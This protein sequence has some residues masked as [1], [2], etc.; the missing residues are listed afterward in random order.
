LQIWIDGDACPKVIKS[1]LFRAAMRTK[2]NLI[3]VANHFASV[4]SSPFIRVRVVE[5]GFDVA[6]NE[7]INN[8]QANDLIITADIVLADQVISKQGA[9][10]NPRGEL[11]STANIKQRLAMRNLSESLRSSGF[12]TGGVSKL[13]QKEI[14]T[15]SN[16][17]DK[18]LTRLNLSS[19]RI[20]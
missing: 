3:I 4:P 19:K 6:D 1:I 2:T 7:I 8:M 11:Y 12:L 10:L 20:S 5:H 13:S 14:Q 17:L 15:F 9:A 18:L 16:N